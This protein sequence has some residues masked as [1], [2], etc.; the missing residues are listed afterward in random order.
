MRIVELKPL[1]ISSLT[2]ELHFRL[3]IE[4]FAITVNVAA[5]SV[6]YADWC[7]FRI[8]LTVLRLQ[9]VF[10]CCSEGVFF[11]LSPHRLFQVGRPFPSVS[12][13][14]INY[15]YDTPSWRGSNNVAD[16]KQQNIWEKNNQ[17]N[18]CVI[19]LTDTNWQTQSPL[20]CDW[21]YAFN[22]CDI[23]QYDLTFV[24]MWVCIM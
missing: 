10:V 6:C 19:L 21:P 16:G 3:F 11:I 2:I 1:W 9:C 12:F 8:L 24:C 22:K 15:E 13:S 14:S 17:T 7:A 23:V 20:L 4:S 18:N 5:I